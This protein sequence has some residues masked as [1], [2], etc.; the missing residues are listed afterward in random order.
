MHPILA[1][2][3][4]WAWGGFLLFVLAMLALDLGVFHRELATVHPV[5][6]AVART[7][8]GG[9]P[10]VSLEESESL[11]RRAT[12]LD[13]ESVTARIQLARTWLV[14]GREAEARAM[15]EEASALEPRSGLERLEVE[16][17]REQLADR[18]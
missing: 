11:L 6:K 13:P 7:F 12:A 5:A 18:S 10:D 4:P 3:S 1:S 17:L 16:R 2:A 14:M 8:L 9:F 15:F